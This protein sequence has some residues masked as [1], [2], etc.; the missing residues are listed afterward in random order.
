MS[1]DST[2]QRALF[3]PERW[4]KGKFDYMAIYIYI[5]PRNVYR[6][7]KGKSDYL[8]MCMYVYIYIWHFS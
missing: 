2:S 8:A 5:S 1:L 3:T 6:W 4:G 7:G